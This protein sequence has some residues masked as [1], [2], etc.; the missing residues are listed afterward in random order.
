MER[1]RHLRSVLTEHGDRAFRRV[2]VNVPHRC[3]RLRGVLGIKP[4]RSVMVLALMGGAYP[5]GR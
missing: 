2:P 3:Q 5:L 1:T 4:K